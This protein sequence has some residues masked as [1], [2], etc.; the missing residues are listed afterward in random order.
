MIA[1]L[2]FLLTVHLGALVQDQDITQ[3]RHVFGAVL[4][5]WGGLA[6]LHEYVIQAKHHLS[7]ARSTADAASPLQP[8]VIWSFFGIT[9]ETLAL[10]TV[11]AGCIMLADLTKSWVGIAWCMALMLIDCVR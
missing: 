11:A 6:L 2:V 1:T 3:T 9:M 4:I 7:S 8:A 10:V 5:A